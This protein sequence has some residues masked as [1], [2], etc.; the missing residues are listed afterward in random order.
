M[1]RG[2]QGVPLE[3]TKGAF[4]MTAFEMP[5]TIGSCG[6]GCPTCADLRRAAVALIGRMG[7]EAVTPER[8]AQVAGMPED[9][10]ALHACGDV[11]ACVAAAYREAIEGMQSRFAARLRSAATRDSGLRDA[12]RDLLVYLARHADVAAFVSIE[13]LNGPRELLELREHLRRGSVASVRR[14]LA[15]FD[16]AAVAPELQVEMLLA[17]MS[18]AIARQV[19][20][21]QTGMLPEVLEPAL[22]MAHACEPLPG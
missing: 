11:D 22:T 14:E 5:P 12:T 16:G 1:L 13:V 15:R 7:L 18:H 20:T 3:E 2:G 21:G 19:T 8:L 10:L 9:V 4:A 17:T 6:P